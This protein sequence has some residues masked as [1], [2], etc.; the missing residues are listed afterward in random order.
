MLAAAYDH[1]INARSSASFLRIAESDNLDDICVCVQN[2]DPVSRAA[3]LRHATPVHRRQLAKRRWREACADIRGLLRWTRG[4][5]ERPI[6]KVR[7][8]RDFA[9]RF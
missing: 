7:P 3:A 9:E 6:L 5:A 8:P 2:M 4:A 1:E